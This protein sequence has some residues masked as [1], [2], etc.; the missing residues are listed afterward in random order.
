MAAPRSVYSWDIVIQKLN[1]Q[2]FLDKRENSNFDFLTVSE[3]A[4]EP[5]IINEEM[6]A[7]NY[8]ENLSMEA[9]R[10]N[11]NFSQQILM[12]FDDATRKQV[13]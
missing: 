11:Q 13:F 5:P 8:P 7:M 3:T 2:I 9:T 10:I 1:G 12:D 6:D 4:T